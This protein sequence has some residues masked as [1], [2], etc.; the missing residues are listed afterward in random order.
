MTEQN[1]EPS[2]DIITVKTVS[3][4]L[5]AIKKLTGSEYGK[6]AFR[7]QGDISHSISSTAARRLGITQSDIDGHEKFSQYN[8]NLISDAKMKG[9]GYKGTRE[10][11]ELEI[12]AELQHN[13]AATGLIDFTYSP[14]VALYFASSNDEN[15][16]GVVYIINIHKF[17]KY[18]E[19]T[20]DNIKNKFETFLNEKE[21]ILWFWKPSDQNNRIPIQHSLFIFGKP[22]ISKESI[23]KILIDEDAKPFIIFELQYLHDIDALTLFNDLTGFTKGNGCENPYYSKEYLEH[24][25]KAKSMIT[26]KNHNNK[27]ILGYVEEA[28]KINPI[29]HE[30]LIFCANLKY[31]LKDYLGVIES[32]NKII[33]I[34][35]INATALFMRGR[36]KYQLIQIKDHMNDLTLI[37]EAIE[38]LTRSLQI[39][40]VNNEAFLL[41]ANL[42]LSIQGISP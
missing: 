41:I 15:K 23:K 18:S 36:A 40:P 22:E 30:A 2:E 17:E 8:K 14:L 26:S 29:S 28:L 25:N 7:G 37:N 27:E 34:N 35:P 3:E 24:M 20:S 6:L 21:E 38:D 9:Y 33:E 12:L 39:K 4:Y 5:E 42:K 32:C 16:D 1:D 31:F 10:L 11:N 19:I 13:G